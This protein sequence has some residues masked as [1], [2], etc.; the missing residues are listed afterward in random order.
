MNA[1]TACSFPEPFFSG[2]T[3]APEPQLFDMGITTRPAD[4]PEL[5]PLNKKRVEQYLGQYGNFAYGNV[6]VVEEDILEELI[7]NFDTMSC[8][9]YNA[10]E[11]IICVGS[12]EYWFFYLPAVVFDEANNPSQFVDVTFTP[13][14][15]SIRFERELQ[16]DDAPGPTDDWPQCDQAT[17]QKGP[18]SIKSKR[19]IIW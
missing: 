15:G 18:P 3:P 11:T 14:E 7:L 5:H 12:D 19:P 16:F 1:T 2:S 9:A 10:S 6:S 4:L 8:D 17:A 13:T